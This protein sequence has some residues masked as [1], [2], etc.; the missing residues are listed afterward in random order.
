MMVVRAAKDGWVLLQQHSKIS[1]LAFFL[2]AGGVLATGILWPKQYTGSALIAPN[3]QTLPPAQPGDSRDSTAAM[4][5]E[6]AAHQ[7]WAAI[8]DRFRLYPGMGAGAPEYLASQVALE[9]VAAPELGG[10]EAIRLSYSGGERD[11]V[12]GVI[13]AVA[14]SFTQPVAGLQPQA[15][16]QEAKSNPAAKN[17]EP[18]YAPVILPVPE[19]PEPLPRTTAR[20]AR[21][22][23]AAHKQARHA[24]GAP[25]KSAH[26]SRPQNRQTYP[27]SAALLA[28]LRAS[29]IEGAKLRQ[30]SD[31]NAATLDELRNQQQ[32]AEAAPAVKAPVPIPA[33]RPVDFQL[34][35]LRQELAA[36]Q[37]N[38]DSLR[39]RYTDEYPDVV[40]ARE[41]VQDIQL[42]LARLNTAARGAKPQPAPAEPRRAQPQTPF[43]PALL[44]AQIRQAEAAQT[45]L[46]DAMERNRIETARLEAAIAAE[47]APKAIS[48]QPATNFSDQIAT[49]A[50]EE[51]TPPEQP[52][53]NG[54]AAETPTQGMASI[55]APF[56]LVRQPALATSPFFFARAFLWPLSLVLGL[57]A[58]FAAAW[59]AERRDPS[60]R[61]E[62]ML[63]HELPP[64]AVYLGGIPR[65]RHEVVAD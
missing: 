23:H 57:L 21:R 1:A 20:T 56:F 38:L 42:D 40:I 28:Q 64:S 37:R 46:H 61:N 9:P 4:I 29:L 49:Q 43:D 5:H 25:A 3:L 24:H 59:L 27:Q 44:P 33:P 14:D 15:A 47:G 31:Q 17:E 30:A 16:P 55:P 58:A 13:G 22:L 60:I 34:E 12:A 11:V 52:L 51:I 10:G 35:H 36:A 39:Q 41:K 32:R 63:L 48:A 8:V 50:T 54:S 6:A 45:T 18:L 7:N 19:A 65:I 26:A 62:G 53:S 2:G